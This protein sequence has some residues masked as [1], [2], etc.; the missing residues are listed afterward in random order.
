M[1]QFQP[2]RELPFAPLEGSRIAEPY[3]DEDLL[4]DALSNWLGCQPE[5][6]PSLLSFSTV[7]YSDREKALEDFLAGLAWEAKRLPR[8]EEERQGALD[9]LFQG[10]SRLALSALGWEQRQLD[11]VQTQGFMAV[12]MQF[13]REA[14]RTRPGIPGAEIFQAGR[15]VWAMNSL[16]ALLGQSVRLTPAIFSYSMLYPATD[17]LLDNP[18]RSSLAKRAFQ[19]RFRRRLEGTLTPP[20]NEVEKDI[21]SLVAGIEGQYPRAL[22]PQVFSSLLMI[23]RRQGESIRLQSGQPL[24]EAEVLS[25]SLGKGGASVLADGILVAGTLTP[26]WER[27]TYRLGGF[28]QLLDDLEDLI[29]DRRG[30]R[31]TVF[32]QAAAKGLLDSQSGKL[33]AFGGLIAE[34]MGWLA[35]P[36]ARPLQELMAM[37]LPLLVA[38][39]AGSA[40][41]SHSAAFLRHLEVAVPFRFSTLRKMGSR[42]KSLRG[43]LFRLIEAISIP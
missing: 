27:L 3:R 29:E 39:A 38:N 34:E 11:Y 25:L 18:K 14:Q 1:S 42:L 37:T 7:G 28:L 4:A 36:S 24:S 31:L 22:Y 2:S 35:P 12:A 5:P 9:R 30:R 16:Q 6:P 15:N 17:N 23:H 32:T 8:S 10:F 26:A 20:A 13:S 41:R 19:E 33:L 43:S 40:K 21:F